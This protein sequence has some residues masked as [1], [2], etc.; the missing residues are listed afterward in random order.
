MQDVLLQ[1]IKSH[2][3]F[4]HNFSFFWSVKIKLSYSIFSTIIIDLDL[5][6]RS[7]PSP[8][9]VPQLYRDKEVLEVM[10]TVPVDDHVFFP[11]QDLGL[12]VRFWLTERTKSPSCFTSATKC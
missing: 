10:E 12:G 8:K 5:Q 11:S 4:A 2:F 3:T 1:P 9:D 6:K 7:D